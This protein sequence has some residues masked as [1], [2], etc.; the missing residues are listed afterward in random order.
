MDAS[1]RTL[2]AVLERLARDAPEPELRE[3]LAALWAQ[4]ADGAARADVGRLEEAALRVHRSRVDDQGR[5]AGLTALSETAAD[6]ATHRDLDGL[7]AAICRRVRLL[8]GTDVA[9]ITLSEGTGGDAYIRTT[10]GVVSEAFRSM[11]LPAGRGIG[12]LVA[13][14]GRPEMTADY[15]NDER[16][17]H[18][19][20]VDRRVEAEGLRAIVA[21][22]MRR[23]DEILGVVL[24]GSRA[25]R[26]FEPREVALFASLADHAAIAVE[27]ARL[28]EDSRQALNDLAR[29]HAAVRAHA[30]RVKLVSAAQERLAGL[31]LGGASVADLVEAAAGIVGGRLELR[32]PEGLV[33]V[34]GGA[35][36]KAPGEGDAWLE[37]RVLGGA[38]HLGTLSAVAPDDPG[39]AA[40]VL[41][42]AAALVAGV[43]LQERVDT[44]AEYRRRGRL[45]EELLDGA[46]LPPPALPRPALDGPHVVVVAAASAA[47]QRW[48]WLIAART[49]TPE[50]G[51]VA[52]AAGRTV[53]VVPGDDPEAAGQRWSD[54]LRGSDGARPT[55]GAA[56]SATGAAGLPAAHRE[57]DGVVSLLLAMGNPGRAATSAELGIFGAML[58]E[59]AAP[60]L[61]RFLD[62]T[63]G[64]VVAHDSKGGTQLLSVLS[65]FFEE[66][67]QL[68]NT[69]RRLGIHV[70]TLYQRLARVTQLLG[71]DW[72]ESDRQ[73]ELHL[74]LR[75]RA[76]DE[77][78]AGSRPRSP[79]P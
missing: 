79:R 27:S 7:L 2:V 30:E 75:L 21:V 13:Q 47:A 65:A 56:V 17:A 6:L 69:S 37:R 36:A 42:R 67:G 23:G 16:L 4:A 55:V 11:R 54:V 41:E 57:A 5:A 32:D 9:Y 35:S 38:D 71:E 66:H 58:G 44:E 28:L 12:G 74:A 10:D 61:L 49:A 40:D 29:A 70:N 20:D 46:T 63:L 59:Q 15:V 45:L 26:H 50:H 43:L 1:I 31:A 64:P 78:L 52:T 24:S 22:P 34:A 62:R 53:I 19:R 77:H 76:L 8:L 18:V 3:V 51:L 73:L 68:A 14:T 48:A 33:L 39:T 25:V 60:D 72:R